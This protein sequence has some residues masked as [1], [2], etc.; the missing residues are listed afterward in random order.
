MFKLWQT[1]AFCWSL[2]PEGN[3]YYWGRGWWNRKLPTSWIFGMLE[4]LHQTCLKQ[5]S[6]CLSFT[7]QSLL[8]QFFFIKFAWKW[9]FSMR[10]QLD[11]S[12]SK[13]KHNVMASF[14]LFFLKKKWDSLHIRLNS[15]CKAVLQE[16]KNRKR[17]KHTR[18]LFRMNLQLIGVCY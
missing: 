2:S 12:K 1:R 14:F 18:N 13:I 15:Q 5:M 4:L 16:K 6:C 3:P 9:H 8:S 17:L 11:T 10:N 7:L